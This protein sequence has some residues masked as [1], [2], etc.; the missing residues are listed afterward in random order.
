DI[1]FERVDAQL[2]VGRD[3]ED[4]VAFQLALGPAGEVYREARAAAERHHAAIRSAL[5]EEL[6]KYQTAD[7]IVMDSSSWKVTARNP[8]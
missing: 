1:E 8:S 6:T 3:V 4:A 5:A 7:G 2:T